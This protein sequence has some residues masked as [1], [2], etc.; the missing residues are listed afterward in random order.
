KRRSFALSLRSCASSP[1][2]SGALLLLSSIVGKMSAPCLRLEIL[3][4]SL[5]LEASVTI[6]VMKEAV[7]LAGGFLGEER[8]GGEEAS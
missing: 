8:G 2:S 1:H 6:D 7:A 5:G 3:Q 4:F